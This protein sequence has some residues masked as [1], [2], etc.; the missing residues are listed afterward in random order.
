MVANTYRADWE[1][2]N[3]SQ[4]LNLSLLEMVR[5]EP[6]L[7]SVYFFWSDAINAFLFGHEPMTPTLLD[8]LMLTG[9]NISAPDRSVTFL[10]K[11]SFKV[12]TR[13][14]GG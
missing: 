8:V 2:Y 1:Q 10:D 4:C 5:N 12:E 13:N 11:A 9:L 7:T 14:N 3:I 6:M